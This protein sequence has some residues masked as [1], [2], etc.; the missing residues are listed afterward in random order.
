MNMQNDSAFIHLF[1]TR[2]NYYIYD[3]NTD[4]IL[5]TNKSVYDYLS[6]NSKT[7]PD[8]DYLRANISALRSEGYL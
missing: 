8:E 3:V 5:K 4:M 1:R 2:S 6:S 7:E